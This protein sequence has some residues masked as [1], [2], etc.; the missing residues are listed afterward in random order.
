MS[1]FAL[2]A[3]NVPLSIEGSFFFSPSN[4]NAPSFL[5]DRGLSCYLFVARVHRSLLF[6]CV[7]LLPFAL[8]NQSS[9]TLGKI[10]E[11]EAEE[12]KKSGFDG[13]E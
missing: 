10:R 6:F 5:H 3:C 9:T 1:E 4:I 2:G 11:E 8:V 13:F 12:E 7:V